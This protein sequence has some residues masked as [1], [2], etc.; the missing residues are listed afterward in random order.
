MKFK[1]FIILVLLLQSFKTVSQ[2]TYSNEVT[3]RVNLNFDLPISTYSKLNFNNSES[4]Y[5]ENL[6]IKDENKK[7]IS[8][9]NKG[10]RVIEYENDYSPIIK[11]DLKNN[12]VLSKVKL[13]DKIF[14]VKETLTKIKWKIHKKS[15]D[16]ILGYKCIKATGYFRGR[17]Y[18]AWFTKDIPSRFGPWKLSG[19]PG[20]ILEVKDQLNQVEFIAYKIKHLGNKQEFKHDLLTKETKYKTINLK[21]YVLKLNE[22][23][24][25]K[26]QAIIAKM[27]R[28]YNIVN[29][30]YKKYRG[31]EL[32]YEWEEE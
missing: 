24:K 7:E 15:T 29:L 20:L 16:S 6:K 3:Y 22:D 21:E 9:I 5:T 25:S 14:L 23:L 26:T 11:T 32:K 31:I 4:Y 1:I 10:V 8:E 2:N 28:S 27:P 12:T 18:T 13:S 17:L 19:L 30:E